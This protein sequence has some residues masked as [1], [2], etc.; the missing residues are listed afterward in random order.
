MSGTK[1]KNLF[2]FLLPPLN[3]CPELARILF[4]PEFNNQSA[5]RNP[6]MSE[7]FLSGRFF[8]DKLDPVRNGIKRVKNTSIFRFLSFFSFPDFFGRNFDADRFF[9]ENKKKA[10]QGVSSSS[11]RT[12]LRPATATSNALEAAARQQPAGEK[13][14]AA[15]TVGCGAKGR[16]KKGCV[17]G[18]S[19]KSCFFHPSR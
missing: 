18:S 5:Q 16:L 15:S 4:S 8:P 19:R 9:S 3:D 17:E 10:K 1:K 6:E 2:L 11:I 13:A 7:P 12:R 14:K